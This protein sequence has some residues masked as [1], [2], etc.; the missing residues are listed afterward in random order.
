[1]KKNFLFG[2]ILFSLFI[3]GCALPPPAG[4][5]L[6]E[7][8][9]VSKHNQDA[10]YLLMATAVEAPPP[11]GPKPTSI[12]GIQAVPPIDGASTPAEKKNTESTKKK[13]GRKPSAVPPIDEASVPA[14]KKD[15][16]LLENIKAINKSMKRHGGSATIP[17][18][19]PP[20]GAPDTSS[21]PALPKITPTDN[22]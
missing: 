20:P 17:A 9:K 1:M 19:A 21:K 18:V 11:N 15:N 16:I 14:G 6:S 22:P 13:S 12:K 10:G 7:P 5:S 2:A 3:I 4:A 8:K